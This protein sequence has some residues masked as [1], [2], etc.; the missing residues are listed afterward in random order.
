VDV[1]STPTQ[2]AKFVAGRYVLRERLGEGA[3]G[4]VWSAEDPKIGRRVAVKFLRVPDGLGAAVRTEWESRF[5]LEARAAGRL[6]HPGIVSIYDVGTAS[7]GRPYLV[8]ELV[9]GQTLDALRRADPPPTLEQAVR[10]TIEVAEALD[11]AHRRGVVHRDIKP[12]NILVG[13]DERARI[14]DFGIARLE[15]SSLT[16]DGAFLGSPAF[17]A[18]EQLRGKHIDG[19]ADLFSL[20]AVLYLLATGRRP[21]EGQDIGAIAYS[22]CHVEPALPSSIR[23]EIGPLLDAAILRALRKAPEERFRTGGEFAA[24]LRAAVAEPDAPERTVRE[25]EPPATPPTAE[26]RAASIASAMAIAAVRAARAIEAASLRIWAMLVAWLRR[27]APRVRKGMAEI[28]AGVRADSP[29]LRDRLAGLVARSA[30]LRIERS[31]RW[32]A[33]A[34]T[35]AIVLLALAGRA[36]IGG[37]TAPRH[38]GFVEQLR[39]IVASKTSRVDVVVDHGIEDGVLEFSE[40]GRVL[41]TV[42]LRA[43]EKEL[44]GMSFL[45]RRSGTA[46]TSIRL[47]PGHHALK[48]AV[49]SQDGLDLSKTMDV[50]V[51]PRSE[52]DLRVTVGTWPRKRI[53]ADWDQVE[54]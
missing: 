12:A 21:F 38:R 40:D 43:T 6:S 47:A 8:L 36:W 5:V 10:W 39:E 9:E 25:V 42:S 35:T 2:S 23:S 7:D 18:P 13:A 31:R 32:A 50:H 16:R 49:T 41:E 4:E 20:G 19:R 53:S 54:E 52:Y 29:K 17:A 37:D 24:A 1:S 11:A 46:K 34:L 15:E 22:V 48:I 30:S 14:A 3:V 28:A 26:D 27:T 51:D 33:A 44:F 45:T